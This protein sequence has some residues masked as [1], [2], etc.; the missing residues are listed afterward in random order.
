MHSYLYTPDDYIIGRKK[1]VATELYRNQRY[2]RAQRCTSPRWADER[3]YSDV[4]FRASN[5]RGKSLVIIKTAV[6]RSAYIAP[7]WQ[8]MHRAEWLRGGWTSRDADWACPPALV[9]SF[10]LSRRGFC[11]CARAERAPKLYGAELDRYNILRREGARAF[12]N[13]IGAD[14]FIRGCLRIDWFRYIWNAEEMGY[15]TFA[16]RR[17]MWDI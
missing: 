2:L 11:T 17:E 3:E 15:R 8:C 14:E 12:K 16:R 9:L 10:H 6:L 13:C 7:I 5:K 4:D 1:K